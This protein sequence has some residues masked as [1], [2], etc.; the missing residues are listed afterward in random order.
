[1]TECT[2]G[3]IE[4]TLP[5]ERAAALIGMDVKRLAG[6]IWRD[7]VG[8]PVGCKVCGYVYTDTLP[9]ADDSSVAPR[10]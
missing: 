9:T 8:D 5:L 1:M 4:G 10:G 6:R 2:H 3:P 7:K